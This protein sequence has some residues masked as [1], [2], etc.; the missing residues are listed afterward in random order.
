MKLAFR[1]F[2]FRYK[3][4]WVKGFFLEWDEETSRSRIGQDVGR[5]GMVDPRMG[6]TGRDATHDASSSRS[7]RSLIE[8]PTSPRDFPFILALF[9]TSG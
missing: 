3:I 8:G 2:A 7:P 1:S 5:G 6:V 4:H 9:S